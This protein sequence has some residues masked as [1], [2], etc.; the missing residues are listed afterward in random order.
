MG[1]KEYLQKSFDRTERVIKFYQALLLALIS[2]L[3]WIIYAV[4][5][6]KVDTKVYVLLGV[7]IVIF[8]IL[9]FKVKTLE[10][11]EDEILEE[12]EKTKD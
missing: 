5:E 12:L 4:I 8:F 1:K 9:I 7:G 3:V 2:G 11:K 6:N 10:Y